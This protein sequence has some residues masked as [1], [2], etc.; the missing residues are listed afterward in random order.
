MVWHK[1]HITGYHNRTQ[2]EVFKK[3]LIS[4]GTL[5]ALVVLA[6]ASFPVMPLDHVCFQESVSSDNERGGCE[7]EDGDG[8]Q[9]EDEVEDEDGD[10]HE[11][12]DG[13][14]DGDHHEDE[15]GDLS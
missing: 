12:E 6:P 10:Q 2:S 13:D 9:H 4:R 7:G 8:D 11:D 14:E 5:F 1:L 3:F 15:D